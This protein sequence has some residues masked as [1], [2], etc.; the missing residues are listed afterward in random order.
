VAATLYRWFRIH[1]RRVQAWS[2]VNE[3]PARE[4]MRDGRWL[5]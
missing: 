2:E 1:P 3:L 4:L 5:I